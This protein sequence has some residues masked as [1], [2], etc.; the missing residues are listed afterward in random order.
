LAVI[1]VWLGLVVMTATPSAADLGGWAIKNNPVPDSWVEHSLGGISVFVPPDWQPVEDRARAKVWFGGDM[2]TVSG[3]SVGLI[4]ERD[5]S[6]IYGTETVNVL[7]LVTLP[8][9][10][11]FEQV[12]VSQ[13][14]DAR[15]KIDA[16]IL[17][18]M[19]PDAEGYYTGILLATYNGS[20]DM[21]KDIYDTIMAGMG[22]ITP[23]VLSDS[24]Q[25][26]VDSEPSTTQPEPTDYS[27]AILDGQINL[28]LPD[29]WLALGAMRDPLITLMPPTREG[30]VLLARGDAATG[31]GGLLSGVPGDAKHGYETIMGQR[32]ERFEWRGAGPD[33]L[34][35][36]A[37]TAGTYRLFVLQRCLPE[38]QRIAV[39]V[40][41]VPG[42]ANG[43]VMSKLLGG[44]L[45]ALP[46]DA[47]L[48]PDLMAE[49]VQPVAV[50]MPAE[51]VKAADQAANKPLVAPS[52]P[53]QP[54]APPVLSTDKFVDQGGGYSLYQNDRYGTFI[55]YPS[56]YFRP[57]APPGNG[58]GRSFVSVDGTAKFHIFAQHNALGLSQAEMLQQDKQMHADGRV[59]YERSGPGWYVLSGFRGVDIFYRRVIFDGGDGLVQVFEI[60]YPKTRKTDFDA[61]VG[62]MANSFGPGSSMGGDV[63]SAQPQA[64]GPT[65]SATGQGRY[66]ALRTSALFTPKRGDALRKSLM[67]AARDPISADI[68]QRVIFVVAVLNTDGQWAYLQARPVQPNGSEINWSKTPF[69]NEIRQGVMSD[70]AMVLM[71]RDG[72]VWRVVDYVLGPTD[73]FWLNWIDAY[74]LTKKLFMKR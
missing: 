7:G 38:Q 69:A 14:L 60:S 47:P 31:S 74:D 12:R 29:G 52:E 58:D 63:A 37:F 40:A 71:F 61:I 32:A 22:V 16:L 8:G 34:N 1:A 28:T 51:P 30:F 33:F 56:D 39:Q 55:S 67:N 17:R 44:M 18:S 6:Q 70:V 19:E 35:G 68:G 36:G 3:P 9:G 46:A 65:L 2:A 49:T 73:V 26:S 4:Q 48:C 21:H 23:A 54:P 25:L 11:M 64:E 45:S 24:A 13:P 50:V 59:T 10:K 57:Q 42:F 20:F 43:A 62:Y 5:V 27:H 15:V 66:P 53:L 41:G 72:D